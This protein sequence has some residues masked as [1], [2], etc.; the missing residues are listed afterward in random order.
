MK[1]I[2]RKY[3]KEGDII[4]LFPE[5]PGSYDPSTCQC[6]QHV[7]QHGLADPTHV[8]QTTVPATPE[9]YAALLRELKQIGYDDLRIM[10]RTTYQDYLVRK[11]V[12]RG[13]TPV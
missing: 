5:E 11:K 8:I 7:G 3:Q 4:A 6:Y 2:F 13:E 1:V 9:E 12:I 10:K